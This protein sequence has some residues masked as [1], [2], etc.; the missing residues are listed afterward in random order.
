MKTTRSLLSCLLTALLLL[1]FAKN[2]RADD[3]QPAQTSGAAEV[4]PP[5]SP[6]GAQPWQRRST[7]LVVGGVTGVVVGVPWTLLGGTVTALCLTT[8][9]GNLDP[10]APA[11]QGHCYSTVGFT[12]AGL[13]LVSGGIIGI[14]YGSQRVPVTEE[15]SSLVPSVAIGPRSGS[16]TWQF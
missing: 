3:A 7:P 10:R 13:G 9:R 15:R 8:A 14:L 11:D 6:V 2:A 16:L 12:L 4:R 1:A 5:Q